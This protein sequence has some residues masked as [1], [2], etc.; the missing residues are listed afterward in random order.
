MRLTQQLINEGVLKNTR[1]VEA[2]KE[3]DRRDFLPTS[4]VDDAEINAPLPIGHGQTISQPLTVAF[5]LELLAA[6]PGMKVLDVGSGSG[7]QTAILAELI[8]K[9]GRVYALEVI[10]ELKKFGESNVSKYN[11]VKSKRVQFF[12]ADGWKGNQRE[13]PYDRIIVAAASESI[14]DALIGQ[15]K[16]PGRLVMPVGGRWSQ[17]IILVVKGKD[18]G[19][20]EKRFPGFVFV[21]LVKREGNEQL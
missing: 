19:I 1:L 16:S 11:F 17:D 2:W 14:P 8:G 13:A 10:P 18:G 3:I 12:C 20:T 5:M 15:L 6:E 4:L 7:W 9:E 21:P